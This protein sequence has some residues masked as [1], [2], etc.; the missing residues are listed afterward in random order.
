MSIPLAHGL[1]S[2]AKL[3]RDELRKS[4]RDVDL[5][6]VGT[7]AWLMHH[8]Q[9]AG[10]DH[11][12]YL[13]YALAATEP[14][15][16]EAYVQARGLVSVMEGLQLVGF[17]STNIRAFSHYCT[18]LGLHERRGMP[19]DER[20]AVVWAATEYAGSNGLQAL[21]KTKIQE[22]S[23]RALRMMILQE[24]D[25]NLEEDGVLAGLLTS[26]CIEGKQ[27]AD[28]AAA[29]RHLP[30]DGANKRHVYFGQPSMVLMLM[31]YLGLP[32]SE[33]L[34]SGSTDLERLGALYFHARLL[35][36]LYVDPPPPGAEDGGGSAGGSAGGGGGSGG[37][38]AASAVAA[39]A[40]RSR[41]TP[42]TLGGLLAPFSSSPTY[43][44]T[45]RLSLPELERVQDGLSQQPLP[46][47]AHPQYVFLQR[48][49][50]SPNT[51]HNLFVDDRLLPTGQSRVLTVLNGPAARFADAFVILDDRTTGGLRIGVGVQ[52]KHTAMRASDGGQMK[53]T[54]AGPPAAG[55]VQMDV[56][57]EVAKIGT[58]LLAPFT[59]RT[60]SRDL[61]E[62]IWSVMCT[63]DALGGGVTRIPVFMTNGS[64][65]HTVSGALSGFLQMDCTS[66]HRLYP[67]SSLV[68]KG[69]VR[70]A[71]GRQVQ[72]SHLTKGSPTKV[73]SGSPT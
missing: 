61:S 21:S 14:K 27:L 19:T 9:S 20:A 26:R 34:M 62:A 31:A 15:T 33:A 70:S 23:I 69:K 59:H 38:S 42:R 13:L 63:G 37:G 4:F 48:P 53:A 55:T 58:G 32:L 67:F 29:Y 11:G 65:A 72:L 51:K 56:R 6:V 16:V 45:G 54:A 66:L 24:P 49:I 7:G 39:S 35:A 41:L 73:T 25:P 3:I 17:M 10:S 44:R 28:Y 12:T 40:A 18:L 36:L 46:A 22:V 47:V 68:P 71:E 64:W 60:A 8:D 50:P 5:V 1:C 43:D 57:D 52:M 2:I 30:P